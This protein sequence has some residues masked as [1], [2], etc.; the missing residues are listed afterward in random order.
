MLNFH[1]NACILSHSWFVETLQIL[2]GSFEV[3]LPVVQMITLV[4]EILFAEFGFN[5]NIRPGDVRNSYLH[6]TLQT[7]R[8]T[9]TAAPGP[10]CFLSISSCSLQLLLAKLDYNFV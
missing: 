6:L 8:G 5:G 2:E 7:G 3:R 1:Q 10:S 4:N 9:G